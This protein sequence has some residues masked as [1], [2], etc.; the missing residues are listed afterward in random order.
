MLARQ[1]PVLPQGPSGGAEPYPYDGPRE[2]GCNYK[3][4]FVILQYGQGLL[5]PRLP[6]QQTLK[7]PPAPLAGLRCRPLR[8][9]G[10]V[11]TKIDRSFV[12]LS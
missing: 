3:R 10:K 2:Y 6:Y 1:S 8:A 7:Y 11:F 12:I 5:C 9:K 4:Y